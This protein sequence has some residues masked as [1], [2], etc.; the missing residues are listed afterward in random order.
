MMSIGLFV[1]SVIATAI[2]LY[3][4]KESVERYLVFIAIYSMLLSIYFKI[5]R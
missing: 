3:M 5:G 4:T 2:Y 1:V